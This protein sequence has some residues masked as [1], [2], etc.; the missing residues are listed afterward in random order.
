VATAP[1]RPLLALHYRHR[2]DPAG[3]ATGERQ[4]LRADAEAWL[5]AHPPAPASATA[6]TT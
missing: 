6:A 1:L 2:F 5:A 4:R 3:L